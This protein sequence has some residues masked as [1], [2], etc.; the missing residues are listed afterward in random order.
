MKYYKIN[1]KNVVEATQWTG[2]NLDE[3]LKMIPYLV[4][5]PVEY[6]KAPNVR[7]V[8]IYNGEGFIPLPFRSFVVKDIFGIVS[9]LTEK[10]FNNSYVWKG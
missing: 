8:G 6:K 3:L 5:W 4:E 7:I 10:D 2:D 1:K 9:I